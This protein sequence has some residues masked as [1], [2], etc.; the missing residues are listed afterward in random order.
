VGGGGR[1]AR[2]C[3]ASKRATALGCVALRPRQEQSA[4]RPARLNLLGR[5]VAHLE[6]VDVNDERQLRGEGRRLL[7]ERVDALASRA[8]GLLSDDELCEAVKDE[9]AC[10]FQLLV[11]DLRERTK[12]RTTCFRV[13]SPPAF[14]ATV[15]RRALFVSFL[16]VVVLAIGINP[17]CRK[18]WPSQ[19]I[20]A[21]PEKPKKK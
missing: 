20:T 10:L 4:C 5:R 15:W 7:R 6:G 18:R 12:N 13:V 8:G 2:P 19:G 14:S 9:R 11:R 16:G 3:L 1:G 17:S 21:I